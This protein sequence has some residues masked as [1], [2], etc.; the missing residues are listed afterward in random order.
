MTS[1]RYNWYETDQEVVVS[2]LVK[3]L[4]KDD[5]KIEFGDQNLSFDGKDDNG[6]NYLLN[7]RLNGDILVDDC[8]FK[9]GSVKV[10]IHLKKKTNQRWLKLE[11]E[12]RFRLFLFL[13]NSFVLIFIIFFCLSLGRKIRQ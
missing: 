10:E 7:I 1:P 13:S 8:S 3:N 11:Y 5:V 4:K 9:I 2:I 12:V 6:E